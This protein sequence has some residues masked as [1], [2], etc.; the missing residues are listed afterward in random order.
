LAFSCREGFTLTDIEKD[1]YNR[2]KANTWSSM[3]YS[4][5]P[6]TIYLELRCKNSYGQEVT[7]PLIN[8]GN[9]DIKDLQKYQEYKYFKGKIERNMSKSLFYKQ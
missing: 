7:L 4:D 3:F 6:K 2:F 8:A 1:I 5:L 9:L